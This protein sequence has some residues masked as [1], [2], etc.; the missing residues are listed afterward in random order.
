ML[1]HHKAMNAMVIAKDASFFA[2]M[3]KMSS[4]NARTDPSK[5]VKGQG[6]QIARL[7]V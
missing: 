2:E 7:L 5:V 1:T 6:R 4:E 3:A